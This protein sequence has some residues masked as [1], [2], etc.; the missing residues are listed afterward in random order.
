MEDKKSYGLKWVWH[1]LFDDINN[2]MTKLKAANLVTVKEL[3]DFFKPRS[4]WDNYM[5]L[6]E[7]LGSS[8]SKAY[9]QLFSKQNLQIWQLKEWWK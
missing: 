9:M 4:Y 3:I 1:L 2:D 5:C 6:W 8:W 7:Y